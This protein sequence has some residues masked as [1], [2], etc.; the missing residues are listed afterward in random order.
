V[1]LDVWDEVD[2]RVSI[3]PNESTPSPAAIW[4]S[5]LSTPLWSSSDMATPF[6][7]EVCRV[8]SSTV[9]DEG[10]ILIQDTSCCQAHGIRLFRSFLPD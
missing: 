2:A 9:D 8:V 4:E 7:I 10:R 5:A 6:S 3:R 1:T